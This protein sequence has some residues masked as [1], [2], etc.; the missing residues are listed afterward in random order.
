MRAS[1][2]FF[3]DAS[4]IARLAAAARAVAIGDGCSLPSGC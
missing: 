1:L 3:T 4:D 2:G